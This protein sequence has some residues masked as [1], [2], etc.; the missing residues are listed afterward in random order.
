MVHH[1]DESEQDLL[2]RADAAMYAAKHAGKSRMVLDLC[3]GAAQ[4]VPPLTQ[5][6]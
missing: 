6:A 5:A 1:V 4:E 2:R 3:P